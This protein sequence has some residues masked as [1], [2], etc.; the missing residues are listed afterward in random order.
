MVSVEYALLIQLQ[1]RIVAQQ[2]AMRAILA[3]ALTNTTDPLGALE[4]MRLDLIEAA[5][6]GVRPTGDYEDKVWSAALE[7]LHDELDQVGKRL[8]DDQAGQADTSLAMDLSASSSQ[9]A[10]LPNARV[11]HDM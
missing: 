10:R 6:K 2:M 5:S 8:N 4:E 9:A 3:A 1:A 11:L 7:S